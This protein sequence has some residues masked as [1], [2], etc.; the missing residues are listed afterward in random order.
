MPPEFYSGNY[1]EKLDVFTFG[2][3]LNIIYNGTHQEK[4]PI[5]LTKQAELFQEFI[6]VFVDHDPMKRPESKTISE[7]F[8]LIK[9]I[10]DKII[11][12][13][14][15]FAMYV[16]MSTQNKNLIFKTLYEKIIKHKNDLEISF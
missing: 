12:S 6:N 2:L 4:N 13:E 14:K 3:T 10:F 8:R 11:F 15:R 5:I 16:T 1:N 9:K 7:K